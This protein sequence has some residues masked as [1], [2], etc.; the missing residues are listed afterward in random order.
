[1]KNKKNALI[2]DWLLYVKLVELK[3]FS[4]AARELNLS[5]AT[6]SKAVSRLEDIFSTRLISRNAHKFE[7][8]TAGEIAYD[9]AL[10]ICETYYNL[11]NGLNDKDDIRGELRLSAPGI[12]CDSIVNDW[13][14][15]Y[16]DRHPNVRI[17]LLSREAGGFSSDSPEFDDLVIKSGYL[18]SP[19]LI[20]KNLTPV[21]FGVFASQ[22][23]LRTH[24]VIV[25]PED[26]NNHR[27]LRLSHPSLR[28]SVTFY[29]G[30][31]ERKV[32]LGGIGD[33]QSNNIRSLLHMAR[34]GKGVCVAVPCW[35]V[36]NSPAYRTL[37][38]VLYDWPLAPLPAYLVWRYRK[39][40][41]SLF[42]DFSLFI[43]KKW[44]EL[45]TGQSPGKNR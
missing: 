25:Q 27:L 8:T 33:F 15:E 40:Y 45:F 28:S 26:L 39:I 6:V 37:T 29:G 24:A 21:P 9:N 12:L 19:D 2:F 18:D 41:S 14:I 42:R 38:Q 7:V 36:N 11:L 31:G 13:I 20:Q 34:Q 5:I 32:S 1:M 16:T 22:D 44:N 10:V 17:H 43:E 30:R 4:L 35:V 23:Y 3:S